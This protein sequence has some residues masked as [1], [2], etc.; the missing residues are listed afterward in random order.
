V[1]TRLKE[2]PLASAGLEIKSQGPKE[3]MLVRV[4]KKIVQGELNVIKK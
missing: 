1:K 4:L 2:I 3:G